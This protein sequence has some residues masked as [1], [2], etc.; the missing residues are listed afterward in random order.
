VVDNIINTGDKNPHMRYNTVNLKTIFSVNH[1]IGANSQHILNQN[2]IQ[3]GFR[4]NSWLCWNQRLHWYCFKWS[5][6]CLS[7]LVT[8]QNR[9]DRQL[10]KAVEYCL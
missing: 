2:S 3:Q 7:S 6:S 8:R 5:Q 4:A 10:S 1:L 9:H